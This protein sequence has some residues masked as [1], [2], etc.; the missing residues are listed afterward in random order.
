LLAGALLGAGVVLVAARRGALPGRL[1]L[2]VAAGP[3]ADPAGD[4]REES[5][6]LAQRKRIMG[7]L[8]SLEHVRRTAL[9]IRPLVDQAL[10]Q[11][12]VQ[13]DLA[14]LAAAAGKTPADY[15]AY[16]AGKQEAD[17][18]LESGGDPNARSIANAVGVAQ[19]L[20]ST[21]RRAGLRVDTARSDALSR[22][23]AAVEKS[24]EWL[25]AAPAGWARAPR[26][27]ASP[28]PRER[29]LAQRRAEH[30]SLLA[31]RRR[32]DERFDP[33]KAI[34]VQTRY[35][36]RLT[37]RYGGVDWALQ[38]YHGGEGGVSR[39]VGLHT[40]TRGNLASRAGGL[41]ALPYAELY[42]RV[43]PTGSPAAFSYLY[44]RSD[45]HRY[46][47]WKVRMAERALDLYRRDPAEFE[48]QWQALRPGLPTDSV[49]YGEPEPHSFADRAALAA[50]YREG[51]LV[52]LPPVAARLGVRP[53]EV[54]ALDPASETLHQGL[55]PE[56]MGA[57]LRVAR[58][59]RENGGRS[60]LVVSALVQSAA[61]RAAFRRRH[62][63]KPRPGMPP[64]PDFHATGWCFDLAPPLDPW[65][66]KVLQWA[67]SRLYD[68]L[69]LSWRSETV[70]DATRFHVV[71]NPAHREELTEAYRREAAR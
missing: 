49:Y 28:W 4:P 32:V 70:A 19:F 24:L 59:Y 39:T 42:R 54:A 8:R 38:A 9:E 58:L 20:A 35:L 29:W 46:Y 13:A 36:L 22:R 21:G 47:W 55:R 31:Q 12:E 34:R 67:L 66:R 71:V 5:V 63:E 18:L 52:R 53:R 11:P 69:R 23:I 25:A 61:Y 68:G 43:T 50:G 7:R 40:G 30:R 62:P 57:L 45:D 6:I 51:V 15:R 2:P 41:G 17:L 60:P 48:R 10:A 56:A 26:P 33:A 37:R 27:G 16:F 64:Q 1:E 3:S 44:G 14:Y 65:D